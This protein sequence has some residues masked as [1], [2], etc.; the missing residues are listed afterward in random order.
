MHLW[1]FDQLHVVPRVVSLY[2]LI[3]GIER[4]PSPYPLICDFVISRSIEYLGRS[5]RGFLM[6]R[7]SI[8]VPCLD[9]SLLIRAH[10]VSYDYSYVTSL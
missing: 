10:Y 2:P 1:E 3:C 7:L 6:I 8:Q 9:A 4:F 5:A